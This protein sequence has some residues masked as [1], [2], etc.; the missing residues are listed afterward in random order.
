M[1]SFSSDIC[2]AGEFLDNME[3]VF[4]GVLETSI[5]FSIVAEPI[6]IISRDFD[7]HFSDK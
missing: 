7:F 2:P 1:F 5:L 4:S 3:V 6:E